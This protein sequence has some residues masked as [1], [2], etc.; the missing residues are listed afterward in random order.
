MKGKSFRSLF[1]ETL[2]RDKKKA[3]ESFYRMFNNRNRGWIFY[4]C[5]FLPHPCEQDF[6]SFYLSSAIVIK[7]N[8]SRALY[9]A[10]INIVIWRFSVALCDAMRWWCLSISRLQ[11]VSIIR[12]AY[13]HHYSE[14]ESKSQTL[15]SFLFVFSSFKLRRKIHE[16]NT[17]EGDERIKKSWVLLISL[18]IHEI[19]CLHC[20]GKVAE[21]GLLS[22]KGSFWSE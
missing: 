13:L 14:N 21:L 18:R 9:P 4:L 7:Y 16:N 19:V 2:V 11:R 10:H 22:D 5:F 15:S 8:D 12:D 6:L 17:I 1:K 20:T 3:E